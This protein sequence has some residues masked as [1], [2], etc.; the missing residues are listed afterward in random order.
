M[1]KDMLNY[2]EIA[3][4]RYSNSNERE[5]K[6]YRYYL[7]F[8]INTLFHLSGP[9]TEDYEDEVWAEIHKIGRKI[10]KSGGIDA[11]VMAYENLT[12]DEKSIVQSAWKGIGGFDQEQVDRINQ[13]VSS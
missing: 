3:Q 7:S 8:C 1:R 9:E 4:K 12:A 6:V 2:F 13:R 11:L 10:R 5:L